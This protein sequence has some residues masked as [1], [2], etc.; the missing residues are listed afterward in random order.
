MYGAKNI[1]KTH[2]H[3]HNLPLNSAPDQHDIS[4][5]RHFEAEGA[6]C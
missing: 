3:T 6:V 1:K 2:T 4:G 5:Q